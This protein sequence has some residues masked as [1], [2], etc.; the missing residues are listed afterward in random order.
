M[1]EAQTVKQNIHRIA[2]MSA[3]E[4]RDFQPKVSTCSLSRRGKEFL[5]R[6]C[7]ARLEE[8]D[9]SKAEA[10]NG[11]LDDITTEAI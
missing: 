7:D 2:S 3:D 11:D 5:Y 4:V 8:L 1:S 9:R 6:A 10:V